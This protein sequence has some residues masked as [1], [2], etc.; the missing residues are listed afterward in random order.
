ML[1][2]NDWCE[3]SGAGGAI[4][5]ILGGA[6]G[7]MIGEALGDRI[8]GMAG[9]RLGQALE[10]RLPA[11]PDLSTGS[12]SSSSSAPPP[13][14]TLQPPPDGQLWL[15]GLPEPVT[16]EEYLDPGEVEVDVESVQCRAFF[17]EHFRDDPPPEVLSGKFNPKEFVTCLRTG[18][19][20]KLSTATRVANIALV[21]S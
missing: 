13:P 21:W 19:C 20:F 6:T 11:F 5:G 2:S 16:L 14:P 10:N 3:W 12:S 4:G 9:G 15:P 1:P 7:R 17:K 18:S 8:G